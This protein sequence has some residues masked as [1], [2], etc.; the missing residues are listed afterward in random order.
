MQI[1]RRYAPYPMLCGLLEGKGQTSLRT[2]A[3]GSVALTQAQLSGIR[4]LRD[5][6][7]GNSWRNNLCGV[8]LG[9]GQSLSEQIRRVQR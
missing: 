1:L 3:D 4:G 7:I 5:Q 8:G 6:G 9:G 2:T